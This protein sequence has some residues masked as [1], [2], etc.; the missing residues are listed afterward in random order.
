[1]DKIKLKLTPRAQMKVNPSIPKLL[2]GEKGDPGERGEQGIQGEPGHSPVITAFKSGTTTTIYADGVAIGTVSDGADGAQGPKGD[3]GEAGPKGDTGPQGPKGDI[4]A[5]GPQ[6]PKGDTGA[7]GPQG[8]KGDTGAAGPQG[9]KGDTGATGPQG[10]DGQDGKSAYSYAVDGGYTGTEADFAEKLAEEYVTDVQVNGNSVVTDGVANVPYAGSKPGAVK[11]DNTNGVGITG[12][13][14]LY[15]EYAPENLIKAGTGSYRPICPPRQHMSTFYG[16][17]KAAGDTTQSASSNGIGTYTDEA[18]I[19]IR[20]MLGIYED[21]ELIADYTTTEDA[22]EVEVYTDINGEPFELV[23]ML[24]RA[25]LPRTTTGTQDYV[26]GSTFYKTV[27]GG[28]AKTGPLSTVRYT[29]ATAKVYF[30]YYHEV[31]CGVARMQARAGAS[32]NNSQNLQNASFPDMTTQ[33]N[34]MI[35]SLWGIALK[36]YNASSTLIPAGT[37]IQIYGI[38]K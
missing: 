8:P 31:I 19:A 4:G 13:G 38:R 18:K 5:T 28:S 2:K 34:N 35:T 9:P 6:G 15:V 21:W 37:R 12:D 10:A 17:A 26:K 3:T 24:I 14:K 33:S 7:T 36:Q 11:I 23:K 32:E 29:S 16:L 27:G 1:M 30:E 22:A 20:K 25:S